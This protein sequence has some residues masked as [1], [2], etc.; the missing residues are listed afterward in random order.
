MV[1]EQD[2]P[3]CGSSAAVGPGQ[4]PT[5]CPQGVPLATWGCHPG[6]PAPDIVPAFCAVRFLLCSVS[7][8]PETT[9]DQ[10]SVPSP[11]LP[12]SNGHSEAGQADLQ[13]RWQP[14]ATLPTAP[15]APVSRKPPF[16]C[17]GLCLSQVPA[18]GSSVSVA[19]PRQVL[20][21]SWPGTD[22]GL[23]VIVTSPTHRTP[24]PLQLW[25]TSVPAAPPLYKES[26]RTTLFTPNASLLLP[27]PGRGRHSLPVR[28]AQ[29]RPWGQ[30]QAS[31]GG[32]ATRTVR[33]PGTGPP[34]R[35]TLPHPVL[36]AGLSVDLAVSVLQL[37][38]PM[39]SQRGQLSARSSLLA[40]CSLAQTRQTE[41]EVSGTNLQPDYGQDQERQWRCEAEGEGWDRKEE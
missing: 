33:Q 9:L 28:V 22:P 7:C 21:D 24:R 37:G 18:P 5:S 14:L 29:D 32:T 40:P 13:H 23:H 35:H 16:P 6:A 39:A 34:S 30:N 4:A 1:R 20:R 17:T 2:E 41:H 31:A 15:Q 26:S 25:E 36:T 19:F 11:P 8:G 12:I 10:A 27:L 3:L 38:R